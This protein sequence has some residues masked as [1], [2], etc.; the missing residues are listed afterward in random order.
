MSGRVTKARAR[1]SCGKPSTALQEKLLDAAA[2]KVRQETALQ[3]PKPSLVG[4]VSPATR[5]WKRHIGSDDDTQH[6]LK[7]ARLTRKNLTLFDTMGRNKASNHVAPSDS[8]VDSSTKTTSTTTSGFAIQAYENGILEPGYSKPP[9]NLRDIRKRL[10]QRRGTASPT[11]SVYEDYVDRVQGAGNEATM[12]FEVGAKLLKGYPK[13]Y[14]RVFNR[15]FTRFPKDAGFNNGLSAPRPDFIEG[16]EMGEFRPLPVHKHVDGAALYQDDP[17]S[18]VL[19]HLAGEWKGRGKYMDQARLQSAYDGAAL[20]Y[21]QNQAL[22]YAG[23]SGPLG[24]AEV[25]TFTTDGTN[26]NFYAHYAAPSEDGTLE[27]HQ[28]QYASANVKDTHQ[29]HKDGRRGLRNQQD[30]ARDQSYALRDQLKEHWKK[31]RNALQPIAKEG[32]LPVSDKE[33]SVATNVYRDDDED[34]AGYEVVEQPYQ[35]TPPASFKLERQLNHGK[36]PSSHSASSRS[37]PPANDCDGGSSVQ[38]RK[39]SLS[40]ASSRES[41]RQRSKGEG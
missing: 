22:C 25:T 16:L 29:G 17:R 28:Y 10:A 36:A 37:L 4:Q 21:A 1:R 18:V 30:H 23:K 39:A 12:V 20:V 9:T 33:P 6:Q 31:R 19:P 8:V 13:G 40:Q 38:K 35:P 24:H 3:Q 41:P 7:R 5:L 14:K 27:Y 15:T 26:L 32:P 2:D 34:G 11:E